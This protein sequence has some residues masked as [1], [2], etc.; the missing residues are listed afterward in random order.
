[1]SIIQLLI[2]LFSDVGKFLSL[3]VLVLQLAASGGTFPVE[4]IT[5][6]FRWLNP[7][8]PMTYSIKLI[9]EALISTDN[10]FIFN[11]AIVLI[12]FAVISFL[13]T[14]TYDY[15]KGKN[16]GKEENKKVNKK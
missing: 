13:I 4:T 16:K 12:L 15:I 5:Y 9:K 8:L 10:G 3:V 2:R 6:G 7:L 14:C 11:N 1:M